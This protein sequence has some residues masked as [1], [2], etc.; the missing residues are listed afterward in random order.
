MSSFPVLIAGHSQAKYFNQY[1]SLSETNVLSYSGFRIDQMFNELQ[2]TID[3]YNTV[4]RQPIPRGTSAHQLPNGTQPESSATQYQTTVTSY[5]STKTP[6]RWS[7]VIRPERYYPETPYQSR[8]SSSK[9]PW[10]IVVKDIESAIR[11][12]R[13]TKDTHDSIWDLPTPTPTSTPT[14]T[15]KAPTPMPDPTEL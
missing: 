6:L 1:L 14:P 12:L 3:N 7:P 2:P 5:L 8:W 13:K 10:Y 9:L 4:S 15:P 11:H